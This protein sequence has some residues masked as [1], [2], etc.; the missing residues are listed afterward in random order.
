[1]TLDAKVDSVISNEALLIKPLRFAQS[2]QVD[3]Y[4]CGH[5]ISKYPF[6]WIP[7]QVSENKYWRSSG[8]LTDLPGVTLML[9]RMS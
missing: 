7:Q 6:N 5:T 2:G 1:M 8:C 9:K 3:G 4:F